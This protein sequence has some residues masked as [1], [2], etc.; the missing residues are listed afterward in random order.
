MLIPHRSGD[1]RLF[2]LYQYRAAAGTGINKR[3]EANAPSLKDI[4]LC[5]TKWHEDR[6]SNDWQYTATNPPL[7]QLLPY[8]GSLARGY[9]LID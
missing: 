2:S 9:D 1:G 6:A 3:D 5:K 4:L 7:Y 8:V